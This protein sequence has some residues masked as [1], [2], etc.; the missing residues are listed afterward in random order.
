[1]RRAADVHRRGVVVD[2]VEKPIGGL[3]EQGDRGDVRSH[4]GRQLAVCQRGCVARRDAV[5][6][7]VSRDRRALRIA[8]EDDLGP[9]A[10]VDDVQDSVGGVGDTVSRL[11][12]FSEAG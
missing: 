1:M 12:K 8:A 10:G 3:A 7:D 5:G 4:V 11:R 6:R 2:Q 9:G